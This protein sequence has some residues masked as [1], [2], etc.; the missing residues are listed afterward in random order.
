M[1]T[2]VLPFLFLIFS[3]SLFGQ[4]NLQL[5]SAS[6][7]RPL[8]GATFSNGF[9]V[10]VADPNGTVNLPFKAGQIWII[11]H[12]G[13]QTDSLIA[14]KTLDDCP[15]IWSLSPQPFVQ[16][17]YV[18]RLVETQQG[19]P[20]THTRLEK[21]ELEP[22]NTGRDLPMLLDQTASAVTHSDAGAG[23]GYT[24][25]R[26]RG[27][28]QTRI[29][30]TI[31]GI[32]VNDPESQGV[33]WVN[34]P[35]L[36]S[37]AGSIE[38]Q[39]GAGT[40]TQG[41]GSFGGAIHINTLEQSATPFAR[42]QFSAGSFNSLRNTFEA[43]TGRLSSGFSAELRLSKIQSDGFVDRASSDLRSFYL[44]TA[45]HGKKSSLA[46][47]AFSGKETT[48]QAWY[49]VP[50]HLADSLP[51][52]NSAGTD[53][54]QK[55]TPYENETDN[56]QQDHYQLFFTHRFRENLTL[57]AAGF[58]TRGRGFYEQYKVNDFLP[59]Y[60]IPSLG[61]FRDTS[62]LIRR[63]W[64][65]NHF[66]GGNAVVNWTHR[67]WNATG[68]LGLYHYLG[69]HFGTLNWA[70]YAPENGY[71]LRYYEHPAEKTEF[72]AF[73]RATY[74]LNRQLALSTDI[75]YRGVVY[76]IQGFTA[77][78]NLEVN[79]VFHFVNPRGGITYTPNQMH[80]ISAFFGIAQ[81]EPNRVD[82]ETGPNQKPTHEVLRDLELAYRISGKKAWS[83]I[84]G[85]WMDY[86]NQLVLTGA[87]NDVG[88]YTRTNAPK[89]YRLGVEWEWM[90]KPK[91]YFWFSGNITYSQNRILDFI[92]YLD[93]YDNG[94]QIAI[95]RGTTPI[96]FSPDLTAAAS[97]TLIPFKNLEI[98]WGHKGVSQQ[99]L[100]NSGLNSRRLPSF[101]TS[102]IGL[103]WSHHWKNGITLGLHCTVFNLWN[104]RYAPNGY[105]F[106]YLFNGETT[107]DNFVYPMAGR[108]FMAGFTLRFD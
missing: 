65:D 10:L 80:E 99:F 85:F 62:D 49:G 13:F 56:Y 31:N 52:F 54:G 35:D 83:R 45:Y 53:F 37:S 64:L 96:A 98:R 69:N 61:D 89:S 108:N 1:K 107:T 24:G 101:Y 20:I 81:K 12:L 47:H 57:R 15:K 58:Y 75:Q 55:S 22:L 74:S 87:I 104:A 79:D 102:D 76:R 41:A 46:F 82:Y 94:G 4:W 25:I 27:T 59:N 40:N 92:E 105:T 7:Q 32:P 73:V 21:T 26:I 6:T 68:G 78:P 66:F 77:Q 38:I 93:D 36:I 67:H 29:N 16:P 103:N 9:L 43:G 84:T 33:F 51:T 60:G 95:V 39:R 19:L 34:T 44:K 28:D 2:S 88:A 91:P 90:M 23:I 11:R 71:N 50:Q 97:L 86:S 30:V 72:N 70:Q 48:Y 100:D 63:L 14:P 18:I 5:N 8:A 42:Y 106:G 3:S 17:E